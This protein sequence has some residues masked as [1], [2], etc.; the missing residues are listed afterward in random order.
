MGDGGVG[1]DLEGLL[2]VDADVGEKEQQKDERAGEDDGVDRCAVARVEAGEPGGDEVIPAGGHGETGDSGEDE[3]GGGDEAEL[4]EEDGGHGEEVGEAV[5]AEG[6]AK[7]LGDGS[8]VVDVS[9]GEGEDG[10]GAG[11]EHGA[12]DGRGEDDGL[13]DGAGGVFAFSGEDGDV[14]EAAESAEEH[15]S[16]EGEGDHAGL[17]E[18]E[19]ER[20]VVDGLVAR[21]G[22][23]GKHDEGAVDDEDGD[24]ADVVDPLAELK[25][26][27]GG[28][29]DCEDDD[30]HDG[31]GSE[32][33]FGQPGG[34]GADEVGELGG[35][36]VEDGG[37][38]GDAVEPE[39]PCGHEAA[40][41][42]ECGAGPDVEAAF[43]GH[44]AVEIDDG[45]G[46]G[47]IEED[48]G[49][50][51]GD[52]L[53]AAQTGGDADP[54]A[55]DDAEDLGEDEVAE[56]KLSVQAGLAGLLSGR[57]CGHVLGMVAQS[58]R[59]ARSFLGARR[60]CGLLNSEKS[61]GTTSKPQ[62]L[63]LRFSR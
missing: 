26:A 10:A 2:G 14:F 18:L 62:V 27:E 40:E 30:G 28:G 36:G 48:H 39:V 56:T 17:G 43:E 6:V 32:V 15:L 41:I 5:V 63:R 49:G 16:E 31:E 8:D 23:E 44:L 25:A 22:P 57:S 42:A 55:A 34:G 21:H 38:D 4:Q 58:G 33:V 20:L 52:G 19:G 35:D 59:G 47:E 61:P 50:D 9:A 53:G 3:A 60:F 24:A 45:D 1:E 11:D 7:G 37:G 54:G 51:P 13:A 46:H 29:G 12:D